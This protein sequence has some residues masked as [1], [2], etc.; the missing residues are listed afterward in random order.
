MIATSYKIGHQKQHNMDQN[1]N[2]Y[3][4][5]KFNE[6]LCYT[7]RSLIT[8]NGHDRFCHNRIYLH[9]HKLPYMVHDGDFDDD[10]HGYH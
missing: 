7:V 5:H 1:E 9:T 4:P 3:G 2:K 8:R 10:I 6:I